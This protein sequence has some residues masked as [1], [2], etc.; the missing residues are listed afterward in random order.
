METGTG[1][2]SSTPPAETT[3]ALQIPRAGEEATILFH[4]LPSR[5]FDSINERIDAAL[6]TSIETGL[7]FLPEDM[8]ASGRPSTGGGGGDD[9][10]GSVS[11]GGKAQRPPEKL[12]SILRNLY[13]TNLDIAEAYACRNVFA[14]PVGTGPKRRE[15]IVKAYLAGGVDQEGAGA[16]LS[17]N[18]DG[19]SSATASASAASQHAIP[20]NKEAVPTPEQ[21]AAIDEETAALRK[22]LRDARRKRSDLRAVVSKLGQTHGLAKG[23][24][25]ALDESCLGDKDGAQAI[26][27]SV[28]NAVAGREDLK[29]LTEAGKELMTKLDEEKEARK[30][31]GADNDDDGVVDLN[32]GAA[33]GAAD[34]ANAEPLS[35]EEDME[36]RKKIMRTG[37][38]DELAKVSALLKEK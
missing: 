36:R 26:H 33:G 12:L 6:R 25:R 8:D 15:E 10:V 27:E 17:T 24:K 14:L 16:V 4:S 11:G 19:T 13:G 32:D 3:V 23:A 30:N 31:G 20:P 34:G 22:N 1:T 35:V 29:A 18:A 2:S 5:I 9:A 37:D 21:I 28:S 7:P 38:K